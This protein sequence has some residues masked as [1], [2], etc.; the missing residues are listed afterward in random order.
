LKPQATNHS[1]RPEWLAASALL[2]ALFI[3]GGVALAPRA[4]AAPPPFDQDQHPPAPNYADPAAWAALPDRPGAA[5]E[6]PPND[7]IPLAG[8]G[9][10][11]DVFYIHPTTL[12]GQTHWNQWIDDPETNDWTDVS[13][14]ARQASAFNGCCRVYAPRYRQAGPG[15]LYSTDGSGDKAYDLAYQDVKTAFQYYLAHYNHGRPFILA[16]HSQGTLELYRLIAELIDGKPLEKRFIGAYAV[17]VGVSVGA[18]GQTYVSVQPCRRP[19][20]LRC[21]ASWNSFARS[22]DPTDY[23]Q[24]AEGQ[25]AAK[26]GD[27]GKTLLCVNPLTF[28]MDRPSA[29]AALNLGALPGA[30]S[31][32]PL[33]ALIPD[34]AGADCEDG[35]LIVDPPTDPAFHLT[36]LPKGSLH[37]NDIDLYYENI[38]ANA[39]ER[40]NAYWAERR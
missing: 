25:Y 15:A 29:P 16:G 39:V 11:A 12:R 34:A 18:F 6:V 35:V 37:F 5:D 8:R 32:G 1:R 10:R 14:I 31:H 13:V 4:V 40:V 33:P 24:H 28:D 38:R 30:P 2:I 7:S 36:A 9:A 20:D 21:I 17:G 23:R 22:G 3:T 26:H 27:A 19:A